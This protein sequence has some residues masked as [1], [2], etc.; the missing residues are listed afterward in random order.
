ME[1]VSCCGRVWSDVLC[2][3]PVSPLDGRARRGARRRR[4]RILACLHR[5]GCRAR[6]SDDHDLAVAGANRDCSS[7]DAD[8]SGTHADRSRADADRSRADAAADASGA[9]ADL[10]G[11][12]A[13]GFSARHVGAD[14]AVGARS[15]TLVART[16]SPTG[17][18]VLLGSGGIGPGGGS[19]SAVAGNAGTTAAAGVAGGSAAAPISSSSATTK[20]IQVTNVPGRKGAVKIGFRLA[21]PGRVVV[22]V[23][24]PLPDC[25]RVARFVIQGRRGEN[26]LRFNAHTGGRRLAEGTY[27]VGLRPVGA[28]LTRWVVLLVDGSGARALTPSVAVSA[29]A[30]CSSAPEAGGDAFRDQLPRRN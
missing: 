2:P 16:S 27:L 5:V 8:A 14:V 24:G 11:A 12:D 3:S 23:R 9:D 13:N 17:S 25:S 4:F 22:L 1:G 29:V 28:A 21:R 26:S 18:V 19:G 30:H 15:R 20:G 7:T 6:G 10:A